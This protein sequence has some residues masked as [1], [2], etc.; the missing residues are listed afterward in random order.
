ML[1]NSSAGFQPRRRPTF[2]GVI[3][4]SGSLT[5]T[6][7]GILTLLG[8]NTYSGSTTISAGT[9]QVGNGGSGEFLGS[10]SVSLSNEHCA[11]F[12]SRRRADLQRRRSAARGSL[13]Q[14]GTGI[15][16]LLGSNTYTGGTT[17]SAGTLQVGSGGSGASSA[18]PA[19]C[20]TMAAW[21]STARDSRDFRGVDQRQRQ[22]DADRARAF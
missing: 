1:D 12:Q 10:A 4:G 6:G 3:S 16:T 17:I 21:F 18:A 5:Q 9:L 20:W 7:T 15:L 13:T 2:S 11:G 14:T 19:A 8:S 22:P